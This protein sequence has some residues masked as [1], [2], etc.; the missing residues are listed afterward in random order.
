MFAGILII[1]CLDYFQ[2]IDHSLQALFKFGSIFLAFFLLLDLLFGKV[3]G[4]R[5]TGILFLY[6]VLFSLYVQFIYPL[7]ITGDKY[8]FVQEKTTVIDKEAVSTNE[9]H[10]VVVPESYARYRSEKNLERF[11]IL[12]ITI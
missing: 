12:P 7:T 10:I 11:L 1:F 4:Y 5:I 8:Q 3:K 2:L 9:K 6:F